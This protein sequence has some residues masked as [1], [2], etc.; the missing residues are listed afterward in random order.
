MLLKRLREKAF[1][2]SIFGAQASHGK[3]IMMKIMKEEIK[4]RKREK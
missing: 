1:R 3:M 2:F 4:E